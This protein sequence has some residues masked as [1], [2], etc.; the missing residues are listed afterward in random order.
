MDNARKRSFKDEVYEQFARIG[1]AFSSASRLELID[2]LAQGE[3]AVEELAEETDMSVA[4]TSRHLQVL[5]RERLVRRRKEGTYVY[6]TLAGSEVYRAWTAVRS[7]AESRLAEVE[8]TVR[9]YL[10]D[11][12]ELEAVT[13]AE[14]ETRLE[15]EDV[16]VLDVRPEAE[17]RD[18]HIPGAQSIPVD[19][20]EEHLDQLPEGQEIVAYCRGP[21]CVYSDEAVRR[22]RSTGRSARRLDEGLP[23]WKAAGRPVE[24]AS[25]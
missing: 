8:E 10:T 6:Y 11:R 20:L 15:R 24:T 3:R 7:L 19:R 4:N 22:L 2:L 9:R 25:E 13:A 21:Y 5:R 1:K 17:Y 23:G 12:K 14:L 18:G 16:I